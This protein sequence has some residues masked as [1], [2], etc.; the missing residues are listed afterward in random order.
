MSSQTEKEEKF[1]AESYFS[2]L[3]QAER[4][5][6][7]AMN[8]KEFRSI[9]KTCEWSARNTDVCYG[10]AITN[11]AIVP[12]DIAFEFLLFCNRNPRP[13]PVVEV[14]DPGDPEPKLMAPGADLRTDLPL[15]RVFENGELIDEPTDIIKYWRDDLVCFL[16]GCSCT[17]EWALKAANVSW[18][19]FGAYNT[20]IP[21]IPAG[22]FHGNMVVTVRAF[23][24]T[25]DAVRAVQISSRHLLMHGPPVHIGDPA[26]IGIKELGKPDSFHPY[27]PTTEPPKPGEIIMCWGC[28]VTPQ[29]V[30][31]ESKIPFMITHSPAHMFI[32]D[33]LGE[34][35]TII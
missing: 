8:P 18:R 5:R 4:E 3:S 31:L 24:T 32:T 15:Y 26:A 29:A 13:C 16:L 20:S 10:Y 27:R 12:K 25:H 2:R 30:A 22:R 11:L 35:L 6:I 1:A 19:T 14:T 34:E 7:L 17:F 23:P 28:G 21:C 33:R 9:V